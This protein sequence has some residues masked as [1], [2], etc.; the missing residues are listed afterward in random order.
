MCWKGGIRTPVLRREQIYSLPVLA[1]H[2]PSNVDSLK[3]SN[4][5]SVSPEYPLQCRPRLPFRQRKNCYKLSSANYSFIPDPLYYFRPDCRQIRFIPRILSFYHMTSLPADH[6]F[7]LSFYFRIR[8]LSNKFH[9]VSFHHLF[10]FLNLT[11]LFFVWFLQN[12]FY[13]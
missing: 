6:R 5:H 10:V 8:W 12:V 2:P 4:L 11:F 9:V 1:T 3:D 13:Q 7:S